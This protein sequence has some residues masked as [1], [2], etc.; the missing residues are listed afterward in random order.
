M[1]NTPPKLEEV[2]KLSG[3][4]TY[5][6]V[7]PVEYKKLLVSLRTKGRG[8]VIEGPS[9]IGKTTAVSRALEE[10]KLADKARKLSAR[11]PADLPIIGQVLDE[12]L[13]GLV[14]IDDFHRLDSQTQARLADF[15]KLLADEE[16]DNVKIVL[17]GIN[18]T[19]EALVKLGPDLNTRI[20]TITFESNP[21]ERVTELVEKGERA[22]NVT[23]ATK[24]EIVE[25]ANGSF[26]IAQM[27]CHETCLAE[28]VLEGTNLTADIASSFETIRS[29]VMD[30]L[31]REFFTTTQRFASGTKLK[32]EGRAP[33]LHVLKWLA[34][35]GEWSISLDSAM[36][37]HP[38]LK[39]SVS[40]IVEKGY[41]HALIQG[42][43]DIKRLLHFEPSTNVLSIEDPKYV[44]YIRNL[45]WSQLA[46]GLGFINI[47]FESKYDFALSFAGADR[48]IAE[49]LAAMLADEEFAV[50]YDRFEQA[51]ILAE[52]V[53]AYL[54]PIY[55]SEAKFVV[56]LL[57]PDYPKRIWTK[58]E[59]E[60]FKERFGDAAVIPVWFSNA[61]PGLFDET[62]KVGGFE[63]AVDG[64][65]SVQLREFVEL[66]KGKFRDAIK[67]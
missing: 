35:A 8:I 37:Q 26:F 43:D 46:K 5:T 31:R 63:L 56:C 23:F 47:S 14:I 40:Q 6:F 16:R 42:N 15:I 30:N 59:S 34:E 55:E 64:D 39:G 18:K 21:S 4:P 44:F 10:L 13:D 7:A 60:A 24:A 45:S 27:L 49:E 58:F 22:L 9:G 3:V 11:R 48:R 32:R 33:Y 52:D 29:R 67:S 20:E 36:N 62:R 53:E 19:G 50:F 54:R 41:L 61:P 51:R 17:V 12:Q 25:S 38:E 1:T 65:V 2:F 57:G 28:D 66:C